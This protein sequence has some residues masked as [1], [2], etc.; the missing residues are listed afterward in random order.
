VDVFI[1]VW[2]GTE[3]ASLIGAKKIQKI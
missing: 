1:T 2:A 3:D